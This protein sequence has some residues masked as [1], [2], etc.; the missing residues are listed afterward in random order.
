MQLSFTGREQ[1]RWLIGSTTG[2]KVTK[3]CA[4]RKGWLGEEKKKEE[5]K[6]ERKKEERE[7]EGALLRNIKCYHRAKTS[8]KTEEAYLSK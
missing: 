5:R 6:Q 3:P 4:D 8:L 7:R 2:W 1:G